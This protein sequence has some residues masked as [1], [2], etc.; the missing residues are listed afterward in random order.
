MLN[1]GDSEFELLHSGMGD[2]EISQAFNLRH[3][4][5]DSMRNRDETQTHGDVT[6]NDHRNLSGVKAPTS[7]K[8]K[9]SY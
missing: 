8:R 9:Y 5:P 3:I 6:P 1:H 7:L 2:L 4:G